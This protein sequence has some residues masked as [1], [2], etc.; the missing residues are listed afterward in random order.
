MT[1]ELREIVEL[2]S[3]NNDCVVFKVLPNSEMDLILLGCFDGDETM[4]RIAKDNCDTITIFRKD[5]KPYSWGR[6]ELVTEKTEQK[7]RKIMKLI[8]G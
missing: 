3:N 7:R 4:I 6:N 5:G 8:K 1:K 2:V